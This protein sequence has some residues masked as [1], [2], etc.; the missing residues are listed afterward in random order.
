MNLRKLIDDTIE[1]ATI[2]ALNQIEDK[3]YEQ[4]LINKGIKDIIK[5]AIV[6]KG[7]EVKISTPG[8]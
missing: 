1:E 3:K 6:F 7:K 4:E 8:V 2:A 5:L